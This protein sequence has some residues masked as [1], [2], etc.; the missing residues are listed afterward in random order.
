M[1]LSTAVCMSCQM[2]SSSSEHTNPVG[3]KVQEGS[4]MLKNMSLKRKEL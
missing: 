3:C 4:W 1:M 2:P